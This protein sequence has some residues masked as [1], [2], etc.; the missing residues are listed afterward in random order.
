MDASVGFSARHG[1]GRCLV[2]GETGFGSL[3]LSFVPHEGGSV[4][5]EFVAGNHLQGYDDLVHGGVIATLLD[6]A[7][8]HCLF[9]RGIT[10]VTADLHVRYVHPIVCGSR[11]EIGAEIVKLSPPLFRLRAEVAFE[12]VVA[13]WAE[14]KFLPKRDPRPLLG[15]R[16]GLHN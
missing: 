5:S 12:G 7:M 13:A 15:D 4:R 8:T 11:L 10:A 1:H 14:A 6:A 16:V 2:C 9:H 3:K